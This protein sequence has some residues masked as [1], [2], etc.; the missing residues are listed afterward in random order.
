MNK[1]VQKKESQLK[2]MD[3]KVWTKNPDKRVNN[4]IHILDKTILGMKECFIDI[5]IIETF[6]HLFKK[7]LLNCFSQSRCIAF[8]SVK[9]VW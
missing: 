7:E 8:H 4:S 5:E 2:S 6:Q 9:S 1:A 3:K